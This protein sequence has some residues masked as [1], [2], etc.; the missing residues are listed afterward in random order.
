MRC[1]RIGPS[2]FVPHLRVRQKTAVKSGGHGTV[3]GQTAD[4]CLVRESVA[5][6]PSHHDQN[7]VKGEAPWYETGTTKV[8]I[9]APSPY[10]KRFSLVFFTGLAALARQNCP[11]H[12]C[13]AQLAISHRFES[14]SV[15][16]LDPLHER[17]RMTSTRLK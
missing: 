4:G 7:K 14:V 9:Q 16:Q 3:R 17:L 2:A 8:D 15:C 13:A 10:S 11:R 6:H 1:S 12:V 5:T